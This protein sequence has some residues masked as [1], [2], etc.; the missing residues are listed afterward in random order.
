MKWKVRTVEVREAVVE[1]KTQEE[2][3]HKC[4]VTKQ[5]FEIIRPNKC[6]GLFGL[7]A[8]SLS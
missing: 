6:L 5:M 2:A 3:Q 8:L 1:A 7:H 4:L